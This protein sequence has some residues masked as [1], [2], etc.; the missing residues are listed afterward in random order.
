MCRLVFICLIQG[1]CI[2][3]W[4]HYLCWNRPMLRRSSYQRRLRTIRFR[5]DPKRVQS[6]YISIC[7]YLRIMP[8]HDY[9]HSYVCMDEGI[10]CNDTSFRQNNTSDH[11][12][13][14]QIWKRDISSAQTA[15]GLLPNAFSP[16]FSRDVTRFGAKKSRLWMCS[17]FRSCVFAAAYV[18]V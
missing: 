15:F 5:I 4:A 2:T 13:D 6:L 8:M 10:I 7:V 1:L 3:L 11:S 14:L 18:C 17:C 12:M 9:V 16:A